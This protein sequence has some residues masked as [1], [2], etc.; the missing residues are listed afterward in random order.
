M[1]AVARPAAAS[2][3]P[4]AMPA[5][6]ATATTRVAPACVL[7]L[8]AAHLRIGPNLLPATIPAQPSGAGQRGSTSGSFPDAGMSISL[9][10]AR[11][12]IGAV[13]GA[14]L[15]AGGPARAVERLTVC[16]FQFQ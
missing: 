14:V 13:I 3:A 10:R 5:R 12:L 6:I 16:G 1:S 2:D 8:N 9:V 7:P 4:P 15:L 11:V